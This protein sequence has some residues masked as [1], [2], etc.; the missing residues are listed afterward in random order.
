[1]RAVELL[2]AGPRGT[3]EIA[4]RLLGATASP[5]AAAGAVWALLGEDPRF[6]VDAQ[7]VWSLHAAEIPAPR[8][9]AQNWVVVDVETTGGTP[10]AGHRVTEVAAV[11]V[12]GGKVLSSWSTLVNPGRRIPWGITRLTGITDRMVADAPRFAEL[13][14]EFAALL[15]GRVFVAH[16]AAFD[17]GFVSAE[18]ERTFGVLAPGP[19]LCTVRL[20]RK[21]L[22]HLPSRSLE[23]LIDF[24]G[25]AVERRHRALDDALATS[26]VLLHLVSML[27]EMGIDDWRGLDQLLTRRQPRRRRSAMPRGMDAP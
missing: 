27:E 12:S 21:L 19:Q 7:G 5:G 9:A 18:M 17:W 8:L 3:V 2:A 6:V 16:N 22:P 4:R 14:P 24:F 11:C 20:A 26:R 1:M 15:G 25:L 13:A 10:A 23:A